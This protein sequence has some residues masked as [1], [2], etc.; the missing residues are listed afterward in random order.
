MFED[1]PDEVPDTAAPA[2]QLRELLENARAMPLSASVMVNQ[3]EFGECCRTRSTGCPRS[4][5]RRAGC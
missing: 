3:D 4:C 2:P 1:E 5:A